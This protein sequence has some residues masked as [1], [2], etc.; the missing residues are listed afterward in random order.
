MAAS[1][2]NNRNF[3]FAP[4]S[5]NREFNREQIVQNINNRV[6]CIDKEIKV[7]EKNSFN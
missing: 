6:S 4:I 1:N 5:L 2:I 3:N 7:K